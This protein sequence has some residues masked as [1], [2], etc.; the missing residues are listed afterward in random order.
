MLRGKEVVAIGKREGTIGT[1]PISTD[2][3]AI[4]NV[5]L[6]LLYINSGRQKEYYNYLLQI[7]PRKIIFNPG[8]ENSE[9]ARIAS[10]N[11]IEVVYD[12]A[13]SMINSRLL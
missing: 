4:E 5:D 10:E 8:T 1:C 9:L 11:N 6:V 7:K 13:F 2:K 12:C 3:P